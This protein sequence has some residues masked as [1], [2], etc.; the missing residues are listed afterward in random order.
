MIASFHHLKGNPF[1]PRRANGKQQVGSNQNALRSTRKRKAM[2][3]DSR[4][5]RELANW[6]SWSAILGELAIEREVFAVDLPGFGK[7]PPLA[8][9]KEHRQLLND[10]TAFLMEDS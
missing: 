8:G 2:A 1:V 6:R 4:L 5:G 10:F 3:S 7:T 9:M